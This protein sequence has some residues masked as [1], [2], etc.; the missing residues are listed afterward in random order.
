MA[1]ITFVPG[2]KFIGFNG[3]REEKSLIFSVTG[4]ELRV[5]KKKKEIREEK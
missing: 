4:D 5:G 2:Y 3:G 1:E